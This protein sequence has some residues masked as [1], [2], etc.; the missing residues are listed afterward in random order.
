MKRD[1]VSNESIAKEACNIEIDRLN[2]P[3]GKQDQYASALGG[4]R[5]LEFKRDDSVE[6]K[7]S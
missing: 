4:V 5:V 1:Y 7:A 6:T 2:Q 3:I